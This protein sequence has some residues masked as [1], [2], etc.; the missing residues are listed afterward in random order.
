MTKK[1]LVPVADGIEM[2]EALSIVDV[3]R[4]AG[5]HVDMASVND[6]V[7]T[8]SHNVKIT[9]DKLIGE[10]VAEEYDLVALPGG[11]PGAENLRNSQEL[12]LILNRQNAAD[13]YFGAICASPAVVLEHHGLLEGRKATGHPFFTADLSNRDDSGAKVVIDRNCITSRGA[14]TA[15]DFSLELL[16]LL[17]G[18]KKKK[19]VAAAMVVDLEKCRDESRKTSQPSIFNNVVG[20]IMRGPSSS[21]TA[22]SVRIGLL[23]RRLL[24]EDPL[25]VMVKFDPEGS[26]ATTYRGQGSAMGLAAGLLGMS[27]DHPDLVKAEQICRE[28]GVQLSFLVEKYG[29]VHPNTYHMEL[30]GRSGREGQFVAL[31]TGGGIIQLTELDGRAVH[32]DQEYLAGLLPVVVNSGAALPF[33]RLEQLED[34]LAEKGGMLSQYAV[35]Y[36]SSL[37]NVDAS[38]IF[39]LAGEHLRV[40]QGSVDLGIR[41]TAWKD[42]ILPRQSHLLGEAQ[43]LGKGIPAL[44][45]NTIITNVTAV[46]ETKS[47]MGV[48]AAAPTAGSCG[49]LAGTLIAVA[50]FCEKSE[51]EMVCALLAA[52]LIGVFVAQEGGFAA[53]EGGCQ[54]ECGVAS[55]M[56]AAALVELL[57]G[58][59]KAALNAA[60][61]A[62]QNT[63]GLICDPVADRVEV[64]CLGK[65]IMA[66]LNGVAAANM[67][68]AGFAH[69]IPLAQV[70]VAMKDVGE[71]MDHRF[72]CTCK[73]GLSI[74]PEALNIQ[75]CLAGK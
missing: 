15:V 34:L 55:G 17:M 20:P 6:L 31:S 4:R 19:E 5:A 21:H 66:A 73:G 16:G 43:R 69:V 70:I 61:M 57:G 67:T 9:A 29:A 47:S 25:E 11:I 12:V 8:S 2:I 22:A 1:I 62:M 13:K 26:L 35:A 42:R 37:G 49:T 63:M 45:T 46:M 53:E 18:E 23:G 68:L 14:G 28:Q 59:G 65:N 72:R 39:T 27:I 75:R 71:G 50:S 30:K 58:D 44:L 7:I 33:T 60:S 74:T 52:G 40:M 48:I 54:Y 24:R 51:Q 32:D 36:E 38:Q 41:G 64:P 56:T 3:F 10:C